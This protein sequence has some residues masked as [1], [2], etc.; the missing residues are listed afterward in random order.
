LLLLLLPGLQGVLCVDD[1][2]QLLV[3]TYSLCGDR[4]PPAA[5]LYTQ[6]EGQLKE[7]LGAA[8]LAA[9]QQQQQQQ[10]GGAPV[11]AAFPELVQLQQQVSS[12]RG[13]GVSCGGCWL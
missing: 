9:L 5:P 6:Q 3:V 8:F 4:Q 13:A 10:Q 1:L 11:C 2:L 7:A 12:L